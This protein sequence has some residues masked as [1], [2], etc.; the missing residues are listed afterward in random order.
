MAVRIPVVVSQSERRAGSVADFEHELVT[1]LIFESGLD[2]T[3]IADLKSIQLDTTDH[4]CIE[5]LKGDFALA[6]WESPASVCQ[7]LHRLGIPSLVLVPIDGGL[8]MESLHDSVVPKTVFFIRLTP[9]M[10]IDA[11]VKQ[12]QDL[13]QARSVPVVSLMRPASAIVA[14]SNSAVRQSSDVVHRV[15]AVEKPTGNHPV[16]ITKPPLPEK[17]L[18][19][20]HASVQ[21]SHP[22][23]DDVFP[24][25][26]ELMHDLDRFEL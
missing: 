20:S 10:S 16:E 5:G 11:T 23:S 15:P 9:E 3:L 18:Q 12:L 21:E 2:A 14:S 6:S 1:R 4:L 22:E 7:Q 19:P 26:D 24:N 13:R 25:I 8:K 17:T